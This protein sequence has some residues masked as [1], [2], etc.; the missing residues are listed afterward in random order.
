M[1]WR[2]NSLLQLKVFVTLAREKKKSIFKRLCSAEYRLLLP[3]YI[4]DI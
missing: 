1:I 4:T 2:M 3:N